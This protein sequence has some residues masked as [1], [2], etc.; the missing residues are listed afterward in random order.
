MNLNNCLVV[1]AGIIG[2]LL[3]HELSNRG[4]R[5]CLIER[6]DR[7]MAASWAAG[8]ILS[9]LQ[10]WNEPEPILQMAKRS[11]A[12][13]PGLIE[14]LLQSTGV[15]AEYQSSGLLLL[16]PFDQKSIEDW[17]RRFGSAQEWLDARRWQELEPR[18]YKQDSKALLLPGIAQVRNPRLLKALRLAL[19]ARG[20]AMVSDNSVEICVQSGRCT[21]V[22]CDGEFMAAG[23]VVVAA[24]AW[25]SQILVDHGSVLAVEPVRGQMLAFQADPGLLGHIVLREGQYLIPRRDGLILAGSTLETVGF[26]AGITAAAAKNLHKMAAGLLPALG[27]MKPDYHWSGLRPATADGLPVIGAHPGI[28]GLFLNYG[29]YRNGILLAPAAAEL[30]ADILQGRADSRYGG[31]FSPARSA[32]G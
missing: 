20:V 16:E 5:V 2:L 31:A 11:Q 12:L 28:A 14:R 21:G 7:P 32:P 27:D 25:S 19:E 15:D 18:L 4:L 17:A 6:G 3:A 29:H 22:R 30:L 10:P 9:P 26:D 8:G 1:G 13:Y 23:Q 24:G